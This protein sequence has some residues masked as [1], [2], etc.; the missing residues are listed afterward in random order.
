MVYGT[1]KGVPYSLLISPVQWTSS[2]VSCPDDLSTQLDS[3]SQD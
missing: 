1:S 3:I 2:F